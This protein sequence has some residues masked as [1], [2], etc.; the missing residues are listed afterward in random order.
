MVASWPFSLPLAAPVAAAEA[1]PHRTGAA[2]SA[3]R[4]GGQQLRQVRQVSFQYFA[5]VAAARRRQL[6]PRCRPRC[7]THSVCAVIADFTPPFY[8]M[9]MPIVFFAELIFDAD[10]VFAFSAMS[11][12][13]Q[14]Y[15]ALS[16]HAAPPAVYSPPRAPPSA[17][18]V[19]FH[20]A[21]YKRSLT[22]TRLLIIDGF[23]PLFF[24]R[25][26]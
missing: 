14:R 1:P 6:P 12:R 10:C 5:D 16:Q 8:A 17:I 9:P 23:R 19:H 20:A 22:P 18:A 21:F 4:L 3:A 13:R 24:F 11:R 25:F 7:G 15:A 26:H 2:S